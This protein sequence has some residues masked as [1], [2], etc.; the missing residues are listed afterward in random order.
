MRRVSWSLASRTAQQVGAAGRVQPTLL[1]AKRRL[2]NR[3]D[4]VMFLLRFSREEW[5]LTL[6]SSLNR[7]KSKS[8]WLVFEVTTTTSTGHAMRTALLLPRLRSGTSTNKPLWTCSR[9]NSVTPRIIVSASLALSRACIF[10]SFLR[11][12]VYAA[13][14]ATHRARS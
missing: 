13:A 10:S 12:R 9:A 6:L 5:G 7:K 8:S 11:V 2:R 4:L 14:L 3:K 1:Q